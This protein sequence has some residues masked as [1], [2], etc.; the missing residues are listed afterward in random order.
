L[1]VCGCWFVIAS[2]KQL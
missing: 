2:A 1:L